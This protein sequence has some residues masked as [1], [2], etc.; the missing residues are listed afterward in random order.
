[1]GCAYPYSIFLY[2]IVSPCRICLLYLLSYLLIISAYQ[3]GG[4]AYLSSI[5]SSIS[6]L[7]ALTSRV[8]RLP[9]HWGRRSSPL[10]VPPRV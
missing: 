5:S 9:L 3:I 4:S 1:M 8:Y 2:F 6:P 7:V 10:T